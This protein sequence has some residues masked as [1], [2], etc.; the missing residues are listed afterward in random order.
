MHPVILVDS[1]PGSSALAGRYRG[2][3]TVDHRVERDGSTGTTT[4]ACTSSSITSHPSYTRPPTTLKPR[5]PSRRRL[6]HG[7]GIK[8]ETVQTKVGPEEK[9]P[10][11]G[12]GAQYER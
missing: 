5:R 10:P 11:L 8:S 2:V 9:I 4:P 1:E 6:N 7:A 3:A 12:C